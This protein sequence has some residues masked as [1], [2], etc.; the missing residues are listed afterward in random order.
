MITL[1]LIL[2]IVISLAL[3]AFCSG[4]ESGFFSVSRGRIL[5][6]ARE[7]SQAARSLQTHL[8]NMSRTVTAILVGNNI[9]NVTFSSASA[10]LAAYLYADSALAQTLWSIGAACV[11]LYCGEFLPKLFFSSRPLTRLLLIAPIFRVFVW[12]LSPLTQTALWLTSLFM[13]KTTPQER[14]TMNDLVRILQDRKDGVRL[15]DFESALISRILVMR[16]KG[17]FI[18]VEGLLRAFDDAETEDRS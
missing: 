6:L 13:P 8:A 17:E 2:T 4:S 14:V 18:T 9:A 1:L 15:T 5:H 10:A 11:V 16:R 12:V 7:G 3:S